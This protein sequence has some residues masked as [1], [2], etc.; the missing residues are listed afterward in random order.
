MLPSVDLSARVPTTFQLDW[1]GLRHALARSVYAGLLVLVML[2]PANFVAFA[3]FATLCRGTALA[4]LQFAAQHRLSGYWV[5]SAAGGLPVQPI[6][7]WASAA[8]EVLLW[9]SCA[10]AVLVFVLWAIRF[11]AGRLGGRALRTHHLG[12]HTRAA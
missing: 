11:V 2:L 3:L 9:A 8:W 1:L 6:V 4:G 5:A 10:S 7:W 12:A